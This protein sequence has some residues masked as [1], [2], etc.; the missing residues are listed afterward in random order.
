MADNTHPYGELGRYATIGTLLVRDQLIA[1]SGS[2]PT[3]AQAFVYTAL[4]GESSFTVALAP[5][6]A[7]TAF[8]AAAFGMGLAALVLFD[9]PAASYLVNQVTVLTSGPLTAGDK[10]GVI[11]VAR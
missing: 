7:S 1:P 11:V 8:D 5:A 3:G 10:V 9:T 6:L 2:F 4:G